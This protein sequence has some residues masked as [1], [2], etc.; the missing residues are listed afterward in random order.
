MEYLGL[1]MNTEPNWTA[2]IAYLQ[3]KLAKLTDATSWFLRSSSTLTLK[4]KLDIYRA[5][6]IL[7]ALYGSELWHTEPETNKYRDILN[8]ASRVYFLAI[9][10][11]YRT[12]SN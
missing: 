4:E 10:G 12:I 6:F 5:V 2:H 7:T 9:T 8:R 11:L 1:M 3:K